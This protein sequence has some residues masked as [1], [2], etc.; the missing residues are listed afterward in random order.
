[1]S[2][3][4]H[5]IHA[6]NRLSPVTAQL[7]QMCIANLG[8]WNAAVEEVK[9]WPEYR[10]EP[11]RAL[12]NRARE[13]GLAGL[14][15]KDESQRFGRELG[16]FKAL[17]APY[18]VF[19]ILRDF[20]EAKTS[21]RPSSQEL[22]SGRFRDLTDQV[23]VCVATDGNQGRGLAYGARTFGCRCVTYLHSHVSPGR[24]EAMRALGSI[25]IRINGEYEDSVAR[26][27]EDAK[28][29]DWHFVSSTSWRDFEE[30]IPRYVM[31]AYMVMVEEALAQLPDPRAVT[32]V[33][34][35][36]GVGSIAAAI[37]TGFARLAAPQLP[38]FIIVE[39]SEADCLYRSAAAQQPTP[40]PG[41]L[42]TIMA[43]LACREVSPAAWKILQWLASDFVTI[44]DD[45][46]IEAMRALADGGQDVPI[47]SG[48]SA[49]GGMGVLLATRADPALRDQLGLNRSSHVVLFGGEGATDP[50]I[51]K[52]LVGETPDAVF[53]RQ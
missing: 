32:H 25:V 14:H 33:V 21:H 37:F 39:P 35:Q 19:A 24:A 9:S 47:V 23:T 34:M 28:I 10:P 12:P 30:A 43:G 15:Y 18:A 29:N 11:L 3:S 52:E 48:E 50:Q 20:V 45:L 7:A 41:T 1:M 13:L 26:A 16:S 6:P 44:P 46:A 22:R 36:G 27:R 8:N 40:S 5:H 17:G 42:H 49:A 2:S 51:Y 31:N 38:R 4:V 53:T